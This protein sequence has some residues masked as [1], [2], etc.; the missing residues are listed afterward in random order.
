[1]FWQARGA[2]GQSSNKVS[3]FQTYTDS[4]TSE[5]WLASSTLTGR[6]ALGPWLLKPSASVAYIEDVAA[7]Y[8]D[9][10][11]IVIPEVGARL[12]QAK[13]GPEISYRYQF[14][15]NLVIEPH[16][17]VQVLWNFAGDTSATGLGV[18]SGV[19]AGPLGVRGRVEIGQ[20]ATTASGFA[21]DLSGSYDGIGSSESGG[22]DAYTAK[23]QMHV[24]L[25]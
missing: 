2:W 16:A 8:T 15:P 21:L 25:N 22:Y 4:F 23:A 24:P 18:I 5:R 7:S 10:F 14:S 11:G 13:A 6:W 12:G 9:T 1:V 3:P 19:N 17:E 20:R